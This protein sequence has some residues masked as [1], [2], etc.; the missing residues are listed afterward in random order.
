MRN[1]SFWLTTAL[2]FAIATF[3][4]TTFA[5]ATRTWVSGV[6]DDVN[7]C[8]RTAPCKTF[9]GA[10]SKTAAGGEI[11]ALDSG[12]FGGVTITKSITISGDATAAGIL[13]SGTNGITINT[14][15]ETDVVH[16]R[17]LVFNG[18]G[19]N[20]VGPSA[21]AGLTAV[22][23]L[24]AG[25]VTL[26]NVQISGFNVNGVEIAPAAASAT[27]LNVYL[28]NVKIRD[29]TASGVSLGGAIVRPV[30]AV[31]SNVHIQKSGTGVNV[32]G[33]ASGHVE[34]SAV[35]ASTLGISATTATSIVR[36]S[37]ST[38]TG[39]TTG[40]SSTGSGQIISYNNNRLL[41]NTTNG[42]PTST[43]YQR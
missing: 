6:G 17:N 29:V 21:P 27:P 20:G 7:P 18:I 2:M 37:D 12:G 9:A 30:N 26:D 5:Q 36:L 8:S 11:N 35:S 25:T 23:V 39:N 40:L 24:Q 33:S 34:R 14:A 22:K 13:V 10:I 19:T 16:L 42:A 41:G 43:V 3:A 32:L 15:Q 38:I 4:E 31:L 28:L 1:R